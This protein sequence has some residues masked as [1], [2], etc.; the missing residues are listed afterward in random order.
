MLSDLLNRCV[1]VKLLLGGI[2]DL[3]LRSE[4]F[5]AL[6]IHSSIP[7]RKQRQPPSPFYKILQTTWVVLFFVEIFT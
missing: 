2:V 4:N 7:L 3:L 6:K 5:P 1:T